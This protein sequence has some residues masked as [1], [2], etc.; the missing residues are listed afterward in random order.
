MICCGFFEPVTCQLS[1]FLLQVL[2]PKNM[3]S[4]Y[5]E[6]GRAGRD[7]CPSKCIVFY[8]DIELTKHRLLFYNPLCI[9]S[10]SYLLYFF[11]KNTL[12][13]K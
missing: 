13:S 8:K 10:I 9:F 3:E 7:G 6:I 5:Q 11:I 12:I 1:F 2:A 4:Y